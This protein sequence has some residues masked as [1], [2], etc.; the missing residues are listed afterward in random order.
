MTRLQERFCEEFLI[1]ADAKA[2]A[3]R[4]GY[5]ANNHLIVGKLM[6][7][8]EVRQHICNL[9]GGMKSDKI[10]KAEEIIIFLTAVMRGEV[11][12]LRTSAKDRMHAAELLG[13]RYGIF[14]EKE[15]GDERMTV[16]ISGE[17]DLK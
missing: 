9:M 17:Q 5:S 6:K 8:K 2:A 4:A 10:A 12:E 16:V 11:E 1:D 3:I 7:N 13:K 15:R 14:N